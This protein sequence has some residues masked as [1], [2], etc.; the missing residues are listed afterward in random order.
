MD[1]SYPSK[2]PGNPLEKIIGMLSIF[3]T[4]LTNIIIIIFGI[5]I[6]YLSF[7]ELNADY[8]IIE[9]FDVPQ[10]L[11]EKGYSGRVIAKKLMDQINHI[12][13]DAKSKMESQ[14]FIPIWAQTEL[15]IEVTG[16]DISLSSALRYVKNF[17]GRE[18]TR[19]SGE[20][21]FHKELLELTT[22]VSKKP[23]KT[24]FGELTNLDSLLR[25]AAE[26]VYKS[27]QPYILAAYFFDNDKEASEDIIRYILSHEPS[28][29]DPWAYN[30]WGN[31]YSE[32]RELFEDAIAKYRKAIKLDA[33][34]APPYNGIGVVLFSQ[35]KYDEAIVMFQKAI[36]LNANYADPYNNLGLASLN[37]GDYKN[38]I[39]QFRKAIKLNPRFAEA[40]FNWGLT[41]KHQK[42]YKGAIVKFEK[43]IELDNDG[44]TK[45]R[46][47]NLINEIRIN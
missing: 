46:A 26:Y 20:V 39:S 31:I 29:D 14:L 42:D 41:L 18:S 33:K 43:A 24:V 32:K 2:V 19:I 10:S 4:F 44:L 11:E 45:I 35:E 34:F 13:T 23:S 6:F 27:T 3:R 16:T 21:I 38:A 47:I 1:F 15:E 5:V 40:Y 7:Q 17:L 9:Y 30:L 28:E 8:V 12:E 37:M 36:E 22:R 25:H